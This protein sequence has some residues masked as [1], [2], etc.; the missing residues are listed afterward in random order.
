MS[1]ATQ[2]AIAA[3]ARVQGNVMTGSQSLNPSDTAQ[4][5]TAILVDLTG[6]KNAFTNLAVGLGNLATA[7]EAIENA[8]TRSGQRP[9]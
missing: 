9:R 4:M 8:T 5:L 6:M 3:F 7:V 1:Q 2:N